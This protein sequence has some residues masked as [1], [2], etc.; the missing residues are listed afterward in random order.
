MAAV[1]DRGRALRGVV[2]TCVELGQ[3]LRPDLVALQHRMKEA[4]LLFGV[5]NRMME[6]AMLETASTFNG[7]VARARLIFSR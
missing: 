4:R 2:G 3:A 6:G 7:P 1:F 5:P